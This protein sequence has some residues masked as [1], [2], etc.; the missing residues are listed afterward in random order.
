LSVPLSRKVNRVEGRTLVTQKPAFYLLEHPY[1][2]LERTPE[3]VAVSGINGREPAGGKLPAGIPK[4][5]LSGAVTAVLDRPPDFAPPGR[6]R[7]YSPDRELTRHFHVQKRQKSLNNRGK[8]AREYRH[9]QKKTVVKS[10]RVS[11]LDDPANKIE[12]CGTLFVAFRCG[13]CG[14]TFGHPRTCKER[15]CPE[16]AH[17]RAARLSSKYAD[18]ARELPNPRNLTLTFLS[19]EHIDAD[20]IRWCFAC[21][22]KLTHRKFWKQLTNGAIVGFEVTHTSNGFHL[23]LHVYVS[24]RVGRLPIELIRE[25]WLEITGAHI[26]RIDPVYVDWRKAM[27]EVVKYPLKLTDLYNKPKLLAEYVRA[28]KGVRLVRGYGAFCRFAEQFK[29]SGKLSDIPCPKCGQ[30]GYIEKIASYEPASHFKRTSWGWQF[31]PHAPP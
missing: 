10:L 30:T 28:I 29:P 31:L 22:N 24:S 25:A 4:T 13:H 8:K 7:G 27:S 3:A 19:V 2:E 26:C 15:I 23:H 12:E 18:R 9:K 14:I 17:A 6:L 21:L 20:C 5:N 16:C 11:G 1:Q